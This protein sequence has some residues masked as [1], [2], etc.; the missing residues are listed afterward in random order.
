MDSCSARIG[1]CQH[2]VAKICNTSQRANAHKVSYLEV[3]CVQK[4]ALPH[5]VFQGARRTKCHDWCLEKPELVLE[6]Y[7]YIFYFLHR[8]LQRMAL[9][10]QVIRWSGWKMGLLLRY[11]SGQNRHWLALL[12]IPDFKTK[13]YSRKQSTWIC[14]YIR[15]TVVIQCF[16]PFLFC[17]ILLK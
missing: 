4:H 8:I 2:C 17:V 7:I 5:H 16:A 11:Y 13:L 3:T 1:N 12:L 10:W 14:F 15:R 9:R 6:I